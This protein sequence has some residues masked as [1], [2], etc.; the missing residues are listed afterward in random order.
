VSAGGREDVAAGGEAIL[1]EVERA[2][3][4]KRPALE[5]M[6]QSGREGT[7]SVRGASLHR[8]EAFRRPP[9]RGDV[10]VAQERHDDPVSG[11]AAPPHTTFADVKLVIATDDLDNVE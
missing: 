10:V 9:R 5:F 4:G 6:L 1:A 11:A 3:V 8:G 7:T 2:V